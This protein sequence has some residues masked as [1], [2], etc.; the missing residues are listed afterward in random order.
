[1]HDAGEDAVVRRFDDGAVVVRLPVTNVEGLRS[2][3]FGFLDHAVVLGPAAVRDEVVAWLEGMRRCGPDDGRPEEVSDGARRGGRRV[4]RDAPGRR[5]ATEQLLRILRLVPWVIQR[6]GRVRVAEVARHFGITC[7]QAREDA[8]RASLVGVAPFDPGSYVDAFLDDERD[9]IV[10]GRPPFFDRAPRLSVSEGFAVLAAGKALLA[11]PGAEPTGALGS[12]L[13]KLERVLGDTS[14]IAVE[15]ALPP[16]LDAV[17]SAVAEGRR[18]RVRYY[19]AWRDVEGERRIEPHVVYEWGGR[20]YVD[21][22]SPETGDVRHYRVDRIREL[23]DTGERFEPVRAEPP[24]RPFDPPPDAWCVVVEAPAA[25]ARW[26]TET[27]DCDWEAVG[28]RLRITLTVAGT[29]WLERLLLR[30]GPEAAVVSPPEL[31]RCGAE[32]AGRVLARY[33]EVGTG[34]G[35]T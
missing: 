21:A 22:H 3:L 27:Y 14:G 8:E 28:D 30:L 13:A 2:W 18:L 25:R 17:R 9:E 19:S 29:V 26:V 15:V 33:A 4:G 10:V 5:P 35:A 1:V 24:V 32:V 7:E 31:R 11:V 20:W 6:G 23:S 16:Y 34:A 12:A